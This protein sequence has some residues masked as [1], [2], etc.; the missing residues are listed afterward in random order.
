MLSLSF[1]TVSP[2]LGACANASVPNT[3]NVAAQVS[4]PAIRFR[5][6][7]SGIR[8]GFSSEIGMFCPG[9]TDPFILVMLDRI[10]GADVF[11]PAD[12]QA[13]V[14]HDAGERRRKRLRVFHRDFQ[15]QS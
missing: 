12:G 7:T 10:V 8:S 5:I 9:Q 1:F 11:A 4:T 15:P 2:G 6:I 14:R 3:T 13:A